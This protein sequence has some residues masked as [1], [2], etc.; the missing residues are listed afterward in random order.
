MVD[1]F[2]NI[3]YDFWFDN[4]SFWIP[5]S[6][7]DKEKVDRIIYEKF[8][9]IQYINITADIPFLEFNN[10][11]FIG[12]I[13]FQD[14]FYKHFTRYQLLNSIKPDF[15]DN[16][17]NNIRLTLSKNIFS[18]I[19]KIILDTTETEIIFILML[20]K[21]VKNYKCV[22]EN[23][24]LWCAHNNCSIHEKL[25]ISKFFNDTYKKMFDFNYIYNNVKL[26]NLTN[27]PIEF[28]PSNIC[29]YFPPQFIEL[30]WL[31]SLNLL[32]PNI[33]TISN[34]LLET[35]NVYNLINDTI[36]VS[37]SGGVDSMVTLFLLHYL[38]INKKINNEVIACHII[39][40][41]RIESNYEFNFIKY[42]CSKLNVKL[43][44][45]NI[46]YLTRKNIDRDFY[47]K[48]T[49]DIR[50]NLYKSVSK[51]INT[52][53]FSVY[54]GHIKDDV[55]ENIWSNF[56][57]AQHL[58]DLKKMKISSIQE[59]IKI[60]RPFLN[61]NKSTIFEISHHCYIPYLKN[62]TPEWSNRGKFRNRFYEETHI[63][64]GAS[65]DEKIIQVADTL[66]SVGNII[67]NLIY[68][69][70]YK[71]YNNI[72][73]TI[74]V[75]RAIEAGVDINSWLNIMEYICHNFLQISKPSIHSVKQFVDRLNK[76]NFTKKNKMKFQLKNNLQIILYKLNN[77][78]SNIDNYYIKFFI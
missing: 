40:G 33:Q 37:L 19:H 73:K 62:T 34:I 1:I 44:Y 2:Y 39:Y 68:K 49:R 61:V 66:S 22:I 51:Y 23:C 52:N 60:I 15:D 63:Q 55:V 67:D 35:I 16:I 69:P 20:Y 64:Y 70:I 74:D 42:Y 41:N 31:A 21:H 78:E 8:Y 36:I 38:L 48:I 59:G 32:H 26:F 29:D 28:E 45:Y 12:F 11:T 71:S 9:N 6:N 7:K 18:T 57:K 13:I 54:L 75:S 17:I 30:D 72:E 25:Y 10:K 65:I 46:E 47:E 4:P 24:L 53:K 76:N 43:Y 77:Y 27:Y 5:I 58:F 14:Q 3:I 56:S 50:F